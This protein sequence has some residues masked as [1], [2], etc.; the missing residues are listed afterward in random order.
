MS[1]YEDDATQ[2]TE[3]NDEGQISPKDAL[4]FIGNLVNSAIEIKKIGLESKRIDCEME[5][6]RMMRDIA[7][8]EITKK[9]EFA[10]AF[11]NKTFEERRMVIEK[12]FKVIDEGLENKNYELV[13]LGLQHI[14]AIVKDN[15]FKLFQ[16]T[17]ASQ[18]HTM[19]EDGELS[20]E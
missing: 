7:I 6:Y 3:W 17:T 16:F 19:L 5:K 20:I 8:T 13:N 11:M 9:Y 4:S 1:D 15:P 10:E 14:T 12:Q 2:I 18:R